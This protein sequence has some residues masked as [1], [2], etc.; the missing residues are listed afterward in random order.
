MFP[1]CLASEVTLFREEPPTISSS[2][3]LRGYLEVGTTPPGLKP[4]P[5]QAGDSE[6]SFPTFKQT[7]TQSSST[8]QETETKSS[9]CT[10]MSVVSMATSLSDKQAKVS[11]DP[12]P[13]ASPEE[14]SSDEEPEENPPQPRIQG[15]PVTIAEQPDPSSPITG[16]PESGG[17]AQPTSKVE[18]KHLRPSASQ[19]AMSAGTEEMQEKIPAR[20]DGEQA[21]TLPETAGRED[22]KAESTWVEDEDGGRRQ[23][24]RLEERSLL[25]EASERLEVRRKSSISD[26]ELL[27]KPE[28]CPSGDEQEDGQMLPGSSSSRRSPPLQPATRGDP[29]IARP[30]QLSQQSSSS[31]YEYKQQ[32]GDLS[33]SFINPSPPHHQVSTG[34]SEE[35]EGEGEGGHA[36]EGEEDLQEQPSVKRRQKH[37]TSKH[38]GVGVASMLAGEE[39]PPTSAS[40]SLP[41]HSDS[42]VPPETE[43][44]PSI[45][46]EGNL[47]SDEDAEHLPVDKLSASGA[48]LG[49][50]PPSPWSSP[51]TPD[52]LPA[53]LKDPHP[54]PPQPDVCMVD[55]DVLSEQ[56]SRE[57]FLKRELKGGKGTR[58]SK[59]KSGSPAGRGDVRTRSWTPL[60]HPSK[61]PATPNRKDPDRS[62]RLSKKSEHPGSWSDS[63]VAGKNVKNASG[64]YQ[65]SENASGGVT[66][67]WNT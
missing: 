13:A 32:R 7:E 64:G 42:D 56:R 9:S 15:Q 47:D 27:Q 40:E 37:H 49:P 24:G 25:E 34:D 8:R 22:R 57:K 10:T 26:W 11:E 21:W 1:V 43:E 31:S 28:D 45:T 61:E 53:P 63:G 59:S 41:S 18:P 19:Y 48:G 62:S 5:H 50:R 65:K 66:G 33:P 51:R 58:K 36:Q 44:C 16:P 54:H 39:T 35:D 29:A 52:P 60:K 38:P 17:S 20:E 30:L 46:P 3:Q 12:L 6:R 14:P 4:P 2:S 55:P 67:T 23:R